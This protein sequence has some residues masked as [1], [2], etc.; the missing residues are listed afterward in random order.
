MNRQRRASLHV[1]LDDLEWLRDP[2]DKSEVIK[3]LQTSLTQIEKCM[4]EEQAALDARPESLQWSA[5]NDSMTDNIS[6]LS[7]V[8]GELEILI[9]Q[10]RNMDLYGYGDIK[11]DVIKIV[12]LIKQVIHR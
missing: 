5:L 8:V 4:D 9:E 3:I 12:N 1:V 10:C 11:S 7:E 2:V 6:D